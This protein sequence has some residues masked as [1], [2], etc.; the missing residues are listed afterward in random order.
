MNGGRI[1]M[2]RNAVALPIL[3]A[4]IGVSPSIQAADAKELKAKYEGK[5]F[6]LQHN[7][8]VDANTAKWQNF[9]EGD[10]V[11]LGSKVTVTK[12]DA[13]KATLAFEDPV[14]TVKLEL[15]DAIPDATFVLDR[16]LGA[17]AP[18]TKGFGKTDLEGIK[19]GKILQGMT[20]K[21]VFLAV[22]PPPYSYTPPFRHDSATNH[23]PK[24]GELT[25]MK[26]TYDFLKITF[27]GEKVAD[28]ED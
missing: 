8:H 11:P 5:S 12:I 28:L 23:D 27:S 2:M 16:V 19:Q 1:G 13:K 7:L 22:G 10:F 4:L 25:Y 21:A 15:D 14:R 24:A 6:V 17:T 20:R 26:S 3:L 9:I 18:S